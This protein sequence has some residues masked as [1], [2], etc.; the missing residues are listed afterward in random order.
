MQP[1]LVSKRKQI[2][3][4]L[5]T[6]Q[7]PELQIDLWTLGLIYGIDIQDSTTTITMTFTSP[8]CPFA[9]SIVRE[10]KEKLKTLEFIKEL[11]IEITFEPLWSKDNLDLEVLLEL[12][13]A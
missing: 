1:D 9:D 2:I 12:G 6:I 5:K 8:S 10:I 7:D 11:N 13:L 3:L 4:L